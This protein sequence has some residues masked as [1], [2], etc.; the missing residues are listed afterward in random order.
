MATH[1]Y[2]TY[3]AKARFSEV[4]KKARDG[5]RVV[6]TYRGKEVAE[7]RALPAEEG[8]WIEQRIRYLEE[9]GELVRAK[10]PNNFAHVRPLGRRPGALARFLESRE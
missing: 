5:H 3:E 10:K 1:T 7:L 9:R 4:L 8:S 2:S 6:I